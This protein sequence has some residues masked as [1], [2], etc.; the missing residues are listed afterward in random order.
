MLMEQIKMAV[1]RLLCFHNYKK[2][3]VT[4][5]FVLDILY[6]EVDNYKKEVVLVMVFAGYFFGVVFCFAGYLP[7]EMHIENCLNSDQFFFVVK[8][9]KFFPHVVV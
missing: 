2:H 1:Y 5:D 6:I 3:M 7:V 9:F 4:Q 8:A